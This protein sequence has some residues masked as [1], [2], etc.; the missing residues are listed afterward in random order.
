MK[1]KIAVMLA[2]MLTILSV[3]APAM[4]AISVNRKTMYAN[5]AL[6]KSVQN[7][8]FILQ[9]GEATDTIMIASINSQTG[10]AVM[11]RVDADIEVE[12]DQ[13]KGKMTTVALRDVYMMG[14]AK[15]RGL[16][17]AHEI[18][19]LLDLNI[20]TYIALDIARLPELVEKIGVLNMQFDEAE[21]A[22]MGT[23]VGGNELQGEKVLEYVRLDLESDDAT[24]SRGY[25]ALMQLL[26][27]GLHSGD[28][29]GLVGLGA[30]LL[31]SMDTN[32]GMMTA[33]TMVTAVQGGDDRR[34]V[35]IS[36]D[37]Q[38]TVEEMRALL[39][40]EIYE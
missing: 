22:A 9:D 8:L 16:L 23:W 18:N 2:A 21:A 37:V 17:I 13:G 31:A 29:M 28:L 38:G 32:L 26:Y 3:C 30:K 40:K 27:Q 20:S 7:F 5:K 4:A 10:R 11:T 39:H 19:E 24:R 6:D 25:D 14:D 1:K 15:S 34:E 36:A 35:L 33:M 12:V